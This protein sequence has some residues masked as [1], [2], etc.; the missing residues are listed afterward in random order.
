MIH[1]IGIGLDGINGLTD[2]VRQLINQ[3]TVLVGSKRHL[4]QFAIQ[5]AKTIILGNFLDAITEINSYLQQQERIVVLVSGDPLF[6]GLGRLLLEHFPAEFLQFHPH[7]SSVQLAFNRV[8]IPW[9][10]AKI[11]SAHGRSLDDLASLLQRGEDKIAIL[12]DSQNNPSAIA[13]FYQS[14]NIPVVY[15]FY[16]CENLGADGEKLYHFSDREINNLANLSDNYFA[17]LNVA[18]LLRQD[19]L[20]NNLIDVNHLPILGLNDQTFISFSDRPSLITKK[21]IRLLVLGELALQPEQIIWDIGAGTGSVSLEIARLSP[22]STIYAI[23]KTAIGSTLIEQNCQRLQVANVIPVHGVAPNIL[24]KIPLPQRIFI[25]GSGGNLAEIL[26]ICKHKLLSS[27]IVVLALATVEHINQSITWFKEHQWYYRLLQ[28]QISRSVPVAS[29]T[30]F[31]PLNPVTIITA[32]P[33][34][35]I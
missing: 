28:V 15:E 12:T 25:G 14:L 7:L 34:H 16:I 2:K 23:E 18:I 31:S 10:D 5:T 33:E 8:K 32:M 26:D 13:C 1:V 6:F 24:D 30:R 29:L 9:Q 21:E 11:F 4:Q 19:S 22:T 20:K 27:G 17:P 35:L 3:A